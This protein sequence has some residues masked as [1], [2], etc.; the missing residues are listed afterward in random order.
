MAPM[1]DESVGKGLA[2]RYNAAMPFPHIVIDDFLPP[3]VLE[4]VLVRFESIRC[5][6][7]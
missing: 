7:P 2:A 5:L 3:E 4:Q 1:S 6:I